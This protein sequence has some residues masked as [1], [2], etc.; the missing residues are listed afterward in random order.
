MFKLVF[1]RLQVQVVFWYLVLFVVDVSG[2]V[3]LYRVVWGAMGAVQE[4]CVTCY[5]SIRA[6][7]SG[8]PVTQALLNSS[9]WPL[10]QLK[11]KTCKT[12]L[13][14][15]PRIRWYIRFSSGH[16]ANLAETVKA[17]FARQRRRSLNPIGVALQASP[18]LPVL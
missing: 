6:L 11:G 2:I 3:C 5:K 14:P 9:L 7:V 16:V 17:S 15:G 13:K 10:N 4:G 1:P 12:A 8:M 18:P